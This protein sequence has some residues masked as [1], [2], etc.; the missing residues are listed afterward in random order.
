M[1]DEQFVSVMQRIGM[2]EYE[3]KVFAV[4]F[5]LKFA[6]VREIYDIC[7]IPRN[8]VYESLKSLEKKGF[9]AV[10]G[11]SPLR[12]A[13]TDITQTFRTLKQN[14]LH[15][16][17]E[18]EEFLKSQEKPEPLFSTPHAY[19]LQTEWA[20]QN[21]LKTLLSQCKSELI[22][23]SADTEYLL[24]MIPEKTLKQL[25]RKVNLYLVVKED[26][27]AEGV[28]VPCMTLDSVRIPKTLR[29]VQP[30]PFHK[31]NSKFLLIS[32]R[33]SMLSIDTVEGNLQG[34]VFFTDRNF[35]ISLMAENLIS[36][37]KPLP[38]IRK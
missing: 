23:S 34:M 27:D 6:T 7:G 11:S 18:A 4:I 31:Q 29:D 2:T 14:A 21:H 19:E 25:A 5:H 22:I 30:T 17:S 28:P 26:K 20:I 10:I 3:A 15:E 38:Q 1:I 9:T 36:Y 8:K 35:F 32:D 33:T 16:L 12:Y 37:L 13:K 24:H